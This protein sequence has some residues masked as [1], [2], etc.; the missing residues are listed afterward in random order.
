MPLTDYDGKY[1]QPAAFE[2]LDSFV[3]DDPEVAA[4]FHQALVGVTANAP[5]DYGPF[6]DDAAM[7]EHWGNDWINNDGRGGAF[8]P[9]LTAIDVF[10]A[11]RDGLEASIGL[12]LET[13]KQHLTIWIPRAE[14][15]SAD[16]E[17]T[18]DAQE[19]LFGTAVHETSGSVQLVIVTPRPLQT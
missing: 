10:A 5:G 14:P 12:A 15:P 11:L 8:W 17:L 13:G 9:Y 6:T 19:L 7:R 3:N 1:V 2:L 18:P 4:S 16:A